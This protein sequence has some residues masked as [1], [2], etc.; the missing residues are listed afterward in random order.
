MRQLCCLSA[1]H[2]FSWPLIT[3]WVLEKMMGKVNFS[4]AH[5]FHRTFPSILGIFLCNIDPDHRPEVFLSQFYSCIDE[6]SL[7]SFLISSSALSWIS[8]NLHVGLYPLVLLLCCACPS[9]L[10][11]HQCLGSFI[12]WNSHLDF[13]FS[14]LMASVSSYPRVV[15]FLFGTELGFGEQAWSLR[16]PERLLFGSLF[17]ARQE[18]SITVKQEIYWLVSR[19]GRKV[20]QEERGPEWVTTKVVRNRCFYLDIVGKEWIFDCWVSPPCVPCWLA[21][22]P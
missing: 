22:A 12:I 4:A 1:S 9:I 6:F 19:K 7:S 11:F 18:F 17:L 10:M 16:F 5:S 21:G 20:L 14:K 8:L 2:S 13:F 3:F 15:W